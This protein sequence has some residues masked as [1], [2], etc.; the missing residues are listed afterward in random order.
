MQNSQ[1]G[2]GF[3]L[4]EL[5]VVIV[6]IMILAMIAATIYANLLPRVR[7]T[8]R[9]ADIAILARALELY[10]NEHDSYPSGIPDPNRADW[11][12]SDISPRD[13]IKDFDSFTGG[14]LPIDP[15]NNDTYHYSYQVFPADSF[16]CQKKFFILGVRKFE[17]NQSIGGWRC[18]NKDFGDEFDWAIGGYE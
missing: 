16:G 13:Y 2:K 9:K 7:D 6:I 8:R 14:I 17:H 11:S 15:L 5:M 10:K 12:D 1:A 4:V 3:T 18:P